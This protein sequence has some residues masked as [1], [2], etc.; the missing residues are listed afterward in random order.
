MSVSE[1]EEDDSS[2]RS[3][4]RPWTRWEKQHRIEARDRESGERS[5]SSVQGYRLNLE[6][7]AQDEK[8]NEE[9]TRQ[10]RRVT[11]LIHS[12]SVLTYGNEM[13]PMSYSS[14]H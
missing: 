4:H 5:I 14:A 10:M 6:D 13:S 11:H 8:K 12:E 1:V 2:T 3:S 9:E 7:A